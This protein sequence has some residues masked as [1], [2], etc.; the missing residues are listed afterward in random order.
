MLKYL[1]KYLLP[2]FLMFGLLITSIHA[3]DLNVFSSGGTELINQGKNI[4]CTIGESAIPSLFKDNKTITCGFQ[5]ANSVDITS[6]EMFEEVELTTFPNPTTKYFHIQI[7]NLK[8]V[9]DLKV[10]ITDVNGKNIDIPV[11]FNKL[12]GFNKITCDF[13]S[14]FSGTYFVK[15]V[16]DNNK[17]LIANIKVVRIY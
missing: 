12:N 5:Q 2:G 13:S 14:S 9:N 17:T 8:H 15:I 7:S 16:S 4:S 3:Q 11:S 10:Y 6:I 1:T